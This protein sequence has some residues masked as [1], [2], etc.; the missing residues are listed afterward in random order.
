MTDDQY[1][2]QRALKQEKKTD[3][4]I[5]LKLPAVKLVDTGVPEELAALQ[6]YLHELLGHFGWAKIGKASM[7]DVARE[8][9]A[10]CAS[11]RGMISRARWMCV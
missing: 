7:S 9:P 5:R 4:P 3:K 8:I 10:V 11:L 6:K 2:Q 1:F